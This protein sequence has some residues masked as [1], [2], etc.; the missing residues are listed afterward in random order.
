M[1]ENLFSVGGMSIER[2][3]SF[4]EVAEKGAIAR[5]AEGDPSRQSLISRQITELEAFFGVE[6]TRR[7]GKGLELTSFGEELARQ[8]RLHFHGLS[9]FKSACVKAPLEFRIAAGGSLLE[10]LVAPAMR[11]LAVSVPTS[12]FTLIDWRS[13]EIIRGLLDHRIDAGIV[14]K[15]AVVQPLKSV[16]LGKLS[17]SFFVPKK[18]SRGFKS[19][20]TDVPLATSMGGEFSESLQAVA[21]KAKQTLQITYRCTGFTLAAQLVRCGA[22]GAILPT[23]AENSMGETADLHSVP[24]L[25]NLSR[26]LC[27]VWNPTLLEVRPTFSN[28]LQTLKTELK[29]RLA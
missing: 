8:I 17:Y 21:A 2:L 28:A 22:S 13:G 15:S 10:W 5:V 4:V 6:L 26:E 29:K 11:S 1:F 25:A 3:K 12:S 14:R 9:D 20:P 27:L 23:I 7:R 18:L 16:S 19:F 24:W